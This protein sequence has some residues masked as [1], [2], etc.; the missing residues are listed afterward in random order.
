MSDPSEM[1]VDCLYQ[2]DEEEA[3]D[4][5]HVFTA[6]DMLAAYRHGCD[7]VGD[8]INPRTKGVPVDDIN[9]DTPDEKLP[10]WE[11]MARHYNDRDYR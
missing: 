10:F 2:R 4:T 5:K 3:I 6:E 11:W 9:D 8:V 1:F 7:F